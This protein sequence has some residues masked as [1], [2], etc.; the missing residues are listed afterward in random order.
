MSKITA[1]WIYTGLPDYW[2]GDGERWDDANGC[3]FAFY[4]NGSTLRDIVDNAICAGGDCDTLHE[5][6]T[7]DD[8]RSAIL[9]GCFNDAGRAAYANGVVPDFVLDWDAENNPAVC[10]D[11]GAELGYDHEE[12][13]EILAEIRDLNEDPDGDYAVED[14]DCDD[15]DDCDFCV[16]SPF[17]VFLIKTTLCSE[18]GD[19]DD[20]YVDELCEECTRKHY[21][22]HFN[23]EGEYIG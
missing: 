3:L 10:R 20:H 5:D 1:E 11:C 21:P 13:C 2:S 15:G 18:C 23:E 22:G 4:G 8:I 17:C 19:W 14:D 7:E 12:G 16:D 9:D 6:V